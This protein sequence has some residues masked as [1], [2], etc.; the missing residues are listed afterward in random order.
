MVSVASFPD[1]PRFYLPFAFTTIHRS[2]RPVSIFCR[3]S[4]S[5]YCCE[6]KGKIKTGEAWDHSYGQC[7]LHVCQWGCGYS[8]KS[9]CMYPHKSTHACLLQWNALNSGTLPPWQQVHSLNNSMY[10]AT[11]FEVRPYYQHIIFPRCT[12]PSQYIIS[13][14]PHAYLK[15]VHV[16]GGWEI[17]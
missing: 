6:Q 2:G 11:A 7:T 12:L 4:D 1:F 10:R 5:V 13:L 3:T 15:R 17:K 16:A 14:S 8:F 9:F